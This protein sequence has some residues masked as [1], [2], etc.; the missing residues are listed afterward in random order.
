[1]SDAPAYYRDVV[2][3]SRP[4]PLVQNA[5]ISPPLPSRFIPRGTTSRATPG[6]VRLM[7][8]GTNPGQPQPREDDVYNGKISQALADAA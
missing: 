5:N 7:V 2:S 4:C 3:C 6:K 8:V 1:M